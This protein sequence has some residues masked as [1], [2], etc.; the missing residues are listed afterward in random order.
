MSTASNNDITSVM[1]LTASVSSQAV[2]CPFQLNPYGRGVKLFVTATQASA[3]SFTVTLQG[4]FNGAVYTILASA[5]I[6]ATGTTVLTV[7][8]GL[9]AVANATANDVL[10]RQWQVTITPTAFT[11]VLNIGACVIV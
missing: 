10:P 11:G 9:T 2:T 3:G 8:P 7:Y 4:L 1:A 6:S 5:A